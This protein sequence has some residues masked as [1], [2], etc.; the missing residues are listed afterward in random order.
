MTTEP[1]WSEAVSVSPCT[2]FNVAEPLPALIILTSSPASTFPG[3]TWYV[4]IFTSVAL[5]S[6]FNSVSTVPAGSFAKA[7]LVGAN[8]VNG[9][10]PLSVSTSPP[11]LIATTSVV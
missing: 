7:S 10:L 11:A 5:F 8:T 9:P 1:P 4:R 3:T 2:V 6:G